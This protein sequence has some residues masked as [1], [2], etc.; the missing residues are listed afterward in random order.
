[1]AWLTRHWNDT[2]IVAATAVLLYAPSRTGCSAC[3]LWSDSRSA[4]VLV[5]DLQ[6]ELRCSQPRS[7]V[8]ENCRHPLAESASP[9]SVLVMK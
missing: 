2:W 3:L 1:M 4:H 7:Q 5:I 8:A 6:P 9:S